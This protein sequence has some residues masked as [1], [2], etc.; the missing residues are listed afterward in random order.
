[1]RKKLDLIVDL[2]DSR[3]DRYIMAIENFLF[4]LVFVLIFAFFLNLAATAIS[5]RGQSV[6]IQGHQGEY[7]TGEDVARD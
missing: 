7:Q 2:I 3:A 5:E 6:I 1:M 4:F